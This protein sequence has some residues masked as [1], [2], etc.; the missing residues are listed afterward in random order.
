M[1]SALIV[2]TCCEKNEAVNRR[3]TQTG[4][5]VST[6]PV[7]KLVRFS[8]SAEQSDKGKNST[9]SASVRGVPIFSD[10]IPSVA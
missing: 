3:L 8:S 6:S 9:W 10:D 1:E 7:E 2:N 4:I 5:F